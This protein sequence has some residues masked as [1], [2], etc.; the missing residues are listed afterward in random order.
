MP[1][2]RGR[3]P[4]R[5]SNRR[6]PRPPCRRWPVPPGPPPATSRPRRTSRPAH[7]IR[8]PTGPARP[9]YPV[10]PALHRHLRPCPPGGGHGPATRRRVALATGGLGR[11]VTK[12]GFSTLRKADPRERV[13][14]QFP[15]L[16]PAAV[17]GTGGPGGSGAG[18]GRQARRPRR[19]R[20]C[21][22]PPPTHRLRPPAAR[23]P[24]NGGVSG[25]RDP[26]RSSGRSA[27]TNRDA[28]GGVAADRPRPSGPVRPRF[29]NTGGKRPEAATGRLRA[30]SGDRLSSAGRARPSATA[31]TEGGRPGLPAR[32]P[33]RHDP[34]PS[35]RSRRLRWPEGLGAVEAWTAHGPLLGNTLQK[36][37]V[38]LPPCERPGTAAK[39]SLSSIFAGNR[40]RAKRPHR[41]RPP[42]ETVVEVAYGRN[43]GFG[44][45]GPRGGRPRPSSAAAPTALPT[46][47]GVRW[48][49]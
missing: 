15:P 25:Y 9:G 23:P 35:R 47:L 1:P 43:R 38:R 37:G 19:W 4:G 49:R 36:T 34:D 48:R 7:P 42:S 44:S 45:T 10:Q 8:R 2:W 46:N 27:A 26:G 13:P 24:G 29:P 40:R 12:P 3:G 32:P 18:T 16:A 14:R 21:R 28:S 20:R 30:F 22:P 39:G 17:R 33:G 6:A 41:P 31:G 5:C 11:R